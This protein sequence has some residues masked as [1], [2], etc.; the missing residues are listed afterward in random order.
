MQKRKRKSTDKIGE[1]VRKVCV[2][3]VVNKNK[4]RHFNLIK[5][6]TAILKDEN[7]TVCHNRA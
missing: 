2:C 7:T 5:N 6:L 1:N 3:N 4:N